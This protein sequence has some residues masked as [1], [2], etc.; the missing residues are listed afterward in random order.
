LGFGVEMLMSVLAF[1][2]VLGVLIVLHEAGHFAAA[3]LLGAPVEVFSVGFGKRLWASGAAAPTTGCPAVPSAATC[4][5]SAWART[6]RTWWARP[7]Q[8]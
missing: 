5:S 4:G 1:V 8:S 6:S 7:G 2:F 3:R